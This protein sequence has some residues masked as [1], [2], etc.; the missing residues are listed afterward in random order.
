[1][2]CCSVEDCRR[3]EGLV[4][5]SA[6]GSGDRVE[7]AIHFEGRRKY[8]VDVGTESS[9]FVHCLNHYYLMRV[10]FYSEQREGLQ[11]PLGNRK[12]GDRQNVV[13]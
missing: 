11:N 5:T 10:F 3:K 9:K 1:M 8:E 12:T 2:P 4:L 6:D 7:D 13:Y